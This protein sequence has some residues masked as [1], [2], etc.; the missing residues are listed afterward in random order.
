V[1]ISVIGGAGV[2]TPLLVGGL[3][4]SDLPIE[5]IALYD[6]DR[7]RL[8][9][10]G[11]VAAQM[12]ARG[13][14]TLCES[15][16]ECIAWADFVFPSIRVGGLEQRIH[17]E[18][19]AQ[20]HGIVGQETIGPAGFAM[21][22]RTIPHMVRYAR[23]IAEAAPRA[24]TIVFTNPV[25]MVTEAM[26]T[27]SDRVIGICD[28]PTELFEEAAHVLGLESSACDFDYFGL[29]HL[30]WLR[31]VY[32]HGEPQLHR[33]WA[34][35][36]LLRAIYKVPLFDTLSLRALRMLP[37]EYVY[38]YDQ[39]TRAFDNVRRAGRSRGQAIEELTR[40]LFDAL[41][42][43][44][45]DQIAIYKS[46]LWT[47]SASYMQIEAGSDGL[48]APAPATGL[49]GYDR[50]A[51]GVLRAIHFNANA[52]IPLSV[53]NRGNLAPLQDGDVVEVPCVV[54]ANGA[55][56]LHVQPIPEG[57]VPLLTRVKAYERLSVRA[58]L[59]QSLDGAREAL[60]HNPLV[61]D[62]ATAATLI[63][64]LSPLW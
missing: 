13:R 3:T 63:D 47:R 55:A 19:T 30:G 64:D 17:D 6:V 62:A 43:P 35:D 32:A 58:A 50:I 52:I 33:L 39:P 38:Y 7:A 44:G 53:A 20:R 59:A 41:A 28:T 54:N 12:A 22:M 23:Q 14:V 10:I 27:V 48:T 9:T 60:A 24:W 25:G 4:R 5:Q 61:P 40:V 18:T 51:L 21:A 34:D 11:A 46:Y 29:N 31:E 49:S 26:R 36:D 1:K 8:A 2:R 37:T 56:A 57:I 42:A 15:V 45:A 16:A